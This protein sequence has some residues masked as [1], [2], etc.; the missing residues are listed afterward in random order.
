M[1]YDI[2]YTVHLPK[3]GE[4][5]LYFDTICI[6]GFNIYISGYDEKN[7]DIT[8]HLDKL[9]YPDSRPED[10]G[11]CHIIAY[12]TQGVTTSCNIYRAIR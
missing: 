1:R 6:S 2:L 10:C 11:Y 8:L 4:V 12:S 7:N 5:R 3:I 9:V